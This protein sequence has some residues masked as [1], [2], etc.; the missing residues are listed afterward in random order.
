MKPM[1]SPT[2]RKKVQMISHEEL[3]KYLQDDYVTYLPKD[4]MNNIGRADIDELVED[5][6]TYRTYAEEVDSTTTTTATI[7]TGM[8]DWTDDDDDDDDDDDELEEEDGDIDLATATSE[9]QSI[10]TNSTEA[11]PGNNHRFTWKRQHSLSSVGTS[12][13]TS[14][15]Q[16]VT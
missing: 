12:D 14:T 13:C 11:T 8:E 9:V 2:F 4:G 16:Q 3:Q 10:V 5:F 7:I 1:L 15:E 6:I